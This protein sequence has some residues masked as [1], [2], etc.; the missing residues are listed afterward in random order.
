MSHEPLPIDAEAQSLSSEAT[1]TMW[2]GRKVF[3]MHPVYRSFNAKTHFTMFACYKDYGPERIGIIEPVEGTVIHEARNILV[4]RAMNNL[5]AETFIMIDDDMVLP[6]GSEA[7]FNGRLRA[8]VSPESARFNAISR[9]MS[10]GRDKE[11]VSALYFGRHEFGLA[12]CEWGFNSE[13]RQHNIDFRSGRHRGLIPM[14][15]VATGFMKIERTAIEKLKKAIDE[16]EFPECKP[17]PGQGW[18]G[19][20]APVSTGIGEDVSFG[21][22]MQ[23]IGVQSYLDA[24]LV[25][26]HADGNTMYGPRNTRNPDK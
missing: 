4:D 21:L 2:Q 13:N 8:G 12:Q 7:Y 26:L 25:C 10:H 20:F 17:K 9:I 14:P 5:E 6:C 16:G 15:W 18:Y 1:I 3:L 19:Y 24:S 22:R 11:I 23:K